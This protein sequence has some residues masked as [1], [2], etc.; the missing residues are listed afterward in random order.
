MVITVQKT[1]TLYEFKHIAISWTCVIGS[2][3]MIWPNAPVRYIQAMFSTT[4]TFLYD[5]LMSSGVAVRGNS[6][7]SYNEL[8]DVLQKNRT[9]SK[10]P[11]EKLICNRYWFKL[12]EGRHLCKY[13]GEIT[14]W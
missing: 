12:P 5:L 8:P 6:S 13:D 10:K 7:T 9:P 14:V 1:S 3:A 11:P 2:F 4:I